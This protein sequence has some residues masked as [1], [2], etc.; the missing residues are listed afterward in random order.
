MESQVKHEKVEWIVKIA[1]IVLA[2]SFFIFLAYYPTDEVNA[3]LATVQDSG[4]PISQVDD[5]LNYDLVEPKE[6]TLPDGSIMAIPGF[7]SSP[8]TEKDG[9]W[10]TSENNV[11]FEI[12]LVEDMEQLPAMDVLENEVGAVLDSVV[13][14][15]EF[16]EVQVS[17]VQSTDSTLMQLYTYGSKRDQIVHNGVVVLGAISEKY[18]LVVKVHAQARRDSEMPDLIRTVKSFTAACNSIGIDVT[19]ATKN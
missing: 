8:L 14:S 9:I 12:R 13:G 17:P 16:E 15:E 19:D 5:T 2:V 10:S 18:G 3:E 7:K 11:V 4:V 1:L 6:V